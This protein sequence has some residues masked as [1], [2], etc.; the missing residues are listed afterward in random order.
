MFVVG[1]DRADRGRDALVGGP[2]FRNRLATADLGGVDPLVLDVLVAHDDVPAFAVEEVGVDGPVAAEVGVVELDRAAGS[3]E[4]DGVGQAGL[5]VDLDPH[6]FVGI[7]LGV[8]GD[9][10]PLAAIGPDR[11]APAEQEDSPAV[12]EEGGDDVRRVG[13]GP[14]DGFRAGESCRSGI[15]RCGRSRVLET[16]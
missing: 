1:R 3:D 2:Q 7:A 15:D 6:L 9:A 16:W 13:H 12:A 14:S 10:A 11:V 4:V 8:A 5:L